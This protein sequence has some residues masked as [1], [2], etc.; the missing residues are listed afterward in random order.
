MTEPAHP[1]ESPP[2]DTTAQLLLRITAELG[3]RLGTV[4]LDGTPRPGGE[5]PGPPSA[6][7]GSP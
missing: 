6:P 3:T 2:L 4:R 1:R 5:H 7:P